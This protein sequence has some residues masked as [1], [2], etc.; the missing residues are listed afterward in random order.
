MC[1]VCEPPTSAVNN[2]TNGSQKNSVPNAILCGALFKPAL[3]GFDF[4]YVSLRVARVFQNSAKICMRKT[5][6]A[7][8]EGRNRETRSEAMKNAAFA[9]LFLRFVLCTPLHLF[10]LL[11]TNVRSSS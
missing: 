8:A 2:T 6:L 10:E 4:W 1:E 11:I 9:Q 3:T 7:A 5:I